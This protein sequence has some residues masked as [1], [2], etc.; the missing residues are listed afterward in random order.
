MRSDKPSCSIIIPTHQ[1]KDRLIR[2][3]RSVQAQTYENLEI[4]VSIDGS[5]DG[6]FEAVIAL[7]DPRI[8]VVRSE[9]ATGVA[10]ARNRGVAAS[11]GHYVGFCDDDDF[12]AP[13]KVA[14]QVT[15]MQETEQVWSY[16]FVV[17]IDDRFNYRSTVEPTL[18]RDFFEQL[19]YSNIVPGGCSSVICDRSAFVA[20]GKFD[21]VF[22]MF[23]DWDMW[24]RLAELS[25]PAVWEETGTLYVFHNNQMSLDMSKICPEVLAFRRKY[26]EQRGAFSDRKVEP[27]DRWIAQQL[28]KAGRRYEAIRYRL[29]RD[30]APQYW[31]LPR[32][33]ARVIAR[34][35]R[36]PAVDVNLDAEQTIGQVIDIVDRPWP[37]VAS[38]QPSSFIS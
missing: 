3:L 35:L 19:L 1:R 37:G 2:T 36:P 9:K 22:S 5:T 27:V 25:P 32:S 34:K 20:A 7:S 24:I 11:S 21:P 15:A 10:N 16:S 13:G 8:V 23:A 18:E 14:G 28:W 38:A 6:T 17:T 29:T 26:A 12:W 33:A 30:A 4:V 31:L